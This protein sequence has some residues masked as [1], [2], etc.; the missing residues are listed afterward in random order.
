MSDGITVENLSHSWG[1]FSL[2]NIDLSVP[3]GSYFVLLGPTGSGKTL[4]LEAIAGA[5]SPSEGRVLVSGTDVSHLAPEKRRI[6][7]APQNY[8]LFENMTVRKNVEYGLHARGIEEQERRKRSS[9]L[10]E[11][12]G[13]SHLVERFPRNLSGGERQRVS[14]ARALVVEPRAVLLDEPLSAVDPETKS[15]ILDYLR[16][17]HKET[18]VT[19]IHVTHDRLEA[20]AVADGIGVIREGRITE[21]GSPAEFTERASTKLSDIFASDNLFSGNIIRKEADLALVDIGAGKI[22]EVITDRTGHVMLHVRPE[23]VLISKHGVDSSA[24]NHL[25]GTVTEVT[26]LGPRIRLRVSGDRRVTAMITRRSFFEMGL[27][28]GSEVH[29]FFKA[30]S[31]EVL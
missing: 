27:N 26:D 17:V 15:T 10:L 25:S 24:R 11:I 4:L 18:G 31:V 1:S 5:Y 29:A 21:V 20:A 8:L 3:E 7:Y 23:D 9:H 2:K 13:I 16:R 19:V 30:I 12:L 22:V 14:L 28:I 6:S